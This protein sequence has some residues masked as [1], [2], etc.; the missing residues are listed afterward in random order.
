MKLHGFDLSD[1]ILKVLF[2]GKNRKRVAGNKEGTSPGDCA[3]D[4]ISYHIINKKMY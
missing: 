4:M 3:F 2:N 1:G